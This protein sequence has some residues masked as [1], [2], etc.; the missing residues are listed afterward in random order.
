MIGRKF[1][2]ERIEDES[3]RQIGAIAD[4]VEFFQ[5][6]NAFVEHAITA[7]RVD[8]FRR[9]AGERGD[10]LDLMAGEVFRQIRVRFGFDDRE[11]VAVDDVGIHG[12]S[13]LDEVAKKLTDLGCAARDVHDARAMFDD[14]C[15]DFVGDFFRH[16]LGAVR[17][18]IDMAVR[19][20]LIALAPDVD[21]Q[22]LE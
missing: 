13:G 8:V 17:T 20:G 22:G 19:A 12:A 3:E 5:C 9:V 15:A 7:L 14:P 4:G 6:G 11:V 10:D 2:A 18:S 16:H 21:L 1:R